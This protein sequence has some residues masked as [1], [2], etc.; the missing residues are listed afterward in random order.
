[1]CIRDRLSPTAEQEAVLKQDW[2]ELMDLI[3]TGQ[4]A[5]ISAMQGTYLLFRPKAANA[6]SLIS[7][8]EE[9]GNA[10]LTLPRGFY[11]R[12]S[13]T[14]QILRDHFHSWKLSPLGSQYIFIYRFITACFIR[15]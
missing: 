8:D 2:E 12:T 6:S 3:F 1:M 11:L 7:T 13:F 5:R 14:G 9:E 4:L 15:V 10:A